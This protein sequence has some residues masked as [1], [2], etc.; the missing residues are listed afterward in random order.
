MVSQADRDAI[1]AA[2]DEG[3]L[4]ELAL[5]LGNIPSRSGGGRAHA[6]AGG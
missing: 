2:I 6:D 1:A 5:T 3:E 4:T